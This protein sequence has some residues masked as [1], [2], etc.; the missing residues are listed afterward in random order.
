METEIKALE[1]NNT[2]ILVTL[3]PNH[4]TIGCKWVFKTKLKSDGTLERHK[5]RLVAKGYT[6]EYG[7]DYF[8]TFSPIVKLI[9]V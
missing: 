7:L 8:D 6:Q 3:P 4:H 2:W 5:A 9:T 1:K